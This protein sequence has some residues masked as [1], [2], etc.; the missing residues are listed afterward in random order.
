MQLSDKNILVTGA[1]KGIGRGVAERFISLGAKVWFLARS[2]DQ[3]LS[4]TERLGQRAQVAVADVADY[5]SL[6]RAFDS[7]PGRL[8]VVV[9]NAAVQMVGAD[10]PIADVPIEVWH[11]TTAVNFTGAFHTIRLAVQRMLAQDLINGSRGSIIVSGSPTGVTGEGAG[12]AAYSATKAGVHGMARTTAMDYARQGIRVNTVVPG[13]TLTP[14]VDRLRSDRRTA[15]AID[16]RIPMGRPGTV[17]ECTGIY[18]YLASDE[19]LYATGGMF[20]V[21]GGMTNL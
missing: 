14:M 8:D 16:A 7:I 21:D 5:D 10:A 20:F 3:L 6:A 19:S 15:D 12:F 13:N 4:V 18:A 1:G 11:T 9:V 17:E 2:A